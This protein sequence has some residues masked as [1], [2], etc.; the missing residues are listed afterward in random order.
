MRRRAMRWATARSVDRVTFMSSGLTENVPP[1]TGSAHYRKA[2]KLMLPD[3][4][5]FQSCQ[6]KG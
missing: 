1:N 4:V 2:F 3:S 5:Y 6:P